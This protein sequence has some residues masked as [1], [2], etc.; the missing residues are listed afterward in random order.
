MI[1][2][3]RDWEAAADWYLEKLGLQASYTDPTQGF[4]VLPFNGHTLTIWQL[5]PGEV[6]PPRGT[7]VPY[8]ILVTTDAEAL[9]ATLLKRDVAVGPIEEVEGV[10]FFSL[11]DLDG[12]R[13]EACQLVTGS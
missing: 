5:K 13:L 11:W 12:N 6:L 4:A 7:A 3:V 1:I 10:R 2:R 9:Q 8:P